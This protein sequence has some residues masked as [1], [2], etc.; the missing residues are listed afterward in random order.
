MNEARSFCIGA[1]NLVWPHSITFSLQTNLASAGFSRLN[2]EKFC[3]LQRS[4]FPALQRCGSRI[5]RK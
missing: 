1:E 3:G 2:S 5:F 4:K